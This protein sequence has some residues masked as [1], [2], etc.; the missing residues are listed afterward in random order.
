MPSRHSLALL[1]VLVL[2]APSVAD[3]WIGFRGGTHYGVSDAD[4]LPTEWSDKNNVAWK[5]DLPGPGASCPVVIGSRV[6]VTSYSGYAESIEDPGDMNN[7]VRHVTCLD[8]E[9]GEQV[10]RQDFP[11]E[12]PESEYRPGFDSMHGYASS[13]PTSDGE[14]LYVFF[15]KSGVYCLDL[16]GEEVWHASVGSGTHGWGSSSSPV[17]H[18]DTVV[19]NASVESESVVGLNKRTGDEVWRV[20]GITRCWSSPVLVEAGGRTQAVLNV[21]QRLTSFD[22][23]TGEVIWSC[24]GCP[25]SYLCTSVVAGDGVVYVIGARQ[26]TA[27]AVKADGMGDVTDTHVLWRTNKGSNVCSCV[28][29]EGHL[30]WVHDGRGMAYCLDAETGDVEFEERLDPRPDTVYASMT[31]A[32]GKLYVTNRENVTYVLEATPEDANVLAVNTMES[33]ESRTNASISVADGRLLLRTDKAIYC[34]ERE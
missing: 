22:P 17:V 20:E 28:L 7:L 21:P 31:A 12:M 11:A 34:L 13:T 2:A 23:A 9:T 14:R 27:L 19:V 30:Y 10:W 29:Y 8:M 33:D 26:N 6:Y 24:D 3:D 5:R 16:D 1:L 25:D 15:G 32:D 4:A 18:G